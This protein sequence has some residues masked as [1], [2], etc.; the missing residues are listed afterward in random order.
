M[1]M[2]KN[3]EHFLKGDVLSLHFLPDTVR[4]LDARFD[5]VLHPHLIQRATNGRRELLKRIVA[6][7][8][9]FTQFLHDERVVVGMLILEER[10]SSSVL[11]RFKPSLSAS[12]A[13]I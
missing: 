12:G 9:R 13:K 11:M 10:F 6:L 4:T 1:R 7:E 5:F 2:A 3:V 8:L